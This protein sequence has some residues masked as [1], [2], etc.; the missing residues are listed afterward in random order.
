[1]AAEVSNDCLISYVDSRDYSRDLDAVRIVWSLPTVPETAGTLVFLT[2]LTLPALLAVRPP[3]GALAR[4]V[5][6]GQRERRFLLRALGLDPDP[7]WRG[8]IGNART[9]Q[10]VGSLSRYHGRFAGMRQEYLDFIAAVIALAP[11]RVRARLGADPPAG[12]RAGYWRYV[13]GLFSLFGT[14]LPGEEA[15][16]ASCDSFVREHAGRSAE[17]GALLASLNQHHPAYV[18]LALPS[19]FDSSRLVAASFLEDGS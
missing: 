16:E 5:L 6:D 14:D 10:V 12:D 3:S 4:S 19:L 2:Y 8:G 1:M 11:L 17:G 9:H 7:R 13:S 15:T 18:R